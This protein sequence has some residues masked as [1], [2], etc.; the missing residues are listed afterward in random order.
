[1]SVVESLISI[2]APLEGDRPEAVEA[3][4]DAG[5]ELGVI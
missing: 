4:V 5:K 1:M 3:F 2:V